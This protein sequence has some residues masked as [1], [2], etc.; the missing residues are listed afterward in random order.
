MFVVVV[1]GWLVR[2]QLRFFVAHTH[3]QPQEQPQQQQKKKT[4]HHLERRVGARVGEQK[5]LRLD[6]AQHDALGVALRD[7]AQDV[8]QDARG[9]GLAVRPRLDARPQVA[10]ALLVFLVFGLVFDV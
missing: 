7:G 1:F 9:G 8:S 4:T 3:T 2:I 6:V 10:A 5:V